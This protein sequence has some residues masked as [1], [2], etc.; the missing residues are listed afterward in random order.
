MSDKRK[1]GLRTKTCC[2]SRKHDY[3]HYV[4]GFPTSFCFRLSRYKSAIDFR[5]S[6]LD[7]NSFNHWSTILYQQQTKFHR[8][9]YFGFWERVENWRASSS[10]SHTKLSKMVHFRPPPRYPSLV[11]FSRSF[12]CN[13]KNWPKSNQS[14]VSLRISNTLIPAGID[15]PSGMRIHQ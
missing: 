13:P 9:A 14:D 8:D 11:R 15:N 12:V 4:F 3:F 1:S 5:Y 2:I 10:I 7:T 6:H